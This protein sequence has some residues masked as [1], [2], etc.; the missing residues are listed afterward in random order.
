M[1]TLRSYYTSDML[2]FAIK[3]TTIFESVIRTM[4]I[5]HTDAIQAALKGDWKLAVQLNET[6][7]EE[8]PDDIDTLNRLAFAK[9][10]LG[11][12]KEAKALY[13]KVL[14][15]DTKNPIATRNIKRLS[16]LSAT[17][18]QALM[19]N[20]FIEEPGK[21]KVVELTNIA[22]QKILTPLR[23]G[24]QVSLSVKRMKIFVLDHNKQYIGMLADDL[25]RRLINFMEGGNKYE[26]YIKTVDNHKVIIF[27]IETVRAP[28]FQ[29]HQSFVNPIEKH[30]LTVEHQKARNEADEE[31]EE[32]K[33]DPPEESE[34]DA[35]KEEGVK[36]FYLE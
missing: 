34:E 19:N 6:L 17:Q 12:T 23:S 9:A 7:L 31:K 2:T 36:D 25:S 13:Q 16:S 22:D 35:E 5:P 15:L 3:L 24:E 4:I 11:Q 8:N 32:L 28:Q 20:I 26:A 29:N 14:Q 30:K 18:G 1:L 27:I 10:S 21:T 33:E